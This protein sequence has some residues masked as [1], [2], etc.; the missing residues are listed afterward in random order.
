MFTT[1]FFFRAVNPFP[2]TQ[3]LEASKPKDFAKDNFKF[4]ENGRHFSEW[5]EKTVGKGEIARYE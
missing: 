2:N 4:E 3:I 5:V 1:A